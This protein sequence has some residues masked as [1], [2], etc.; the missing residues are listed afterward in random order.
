[1][2]NKA[3]LED[4]N[5]DLE[6]PSY[7]QDVQ[8]TFQRS[9]SDQIERVHSGP[10]ARI[11]ERDTEAYTDGRTTTHNFSYN[12]IEAP[13]LVPSTSIQLDDN[14]QRIQ[15]RGRS[16]AEEWATPIPVQGTPIPVQ[17]TPIPVQGEAIRH[18][19]K[20]SK[21]EI[22]TSP[23]CG[24]NSYENPLQKNSK[25]EIGTS[26]ACGSNSCENPLQVFGRDVFIKSNHHPCHDSAATCG[27]SIDSFQSLPEIT[28]NKKI[29]TRPRVKRSMSD[30][31]CSISSKFNDGGINAKAF[32]IRRNVNL[33]SC[34][35]GDLFEYRRWAR[36][37]TVV[38]QVLAFVNSKSGGQ[39]IEAIV[40]ELNKL[41]VAICDLADDL[42]PK[43]SLQKVKM[44]KNKNS[45]RFVVLGGDGTVTWLLHELERAHVHGSVAVIPLGTGNDLGRSL[46]WGAQLENI[47]DL[48]Q[49]LQWI[50]AATEVYLDIWRITVTTEVPLP[51]DHKFY[52]PGSHPRPQRKQNTFM[53][54]FQNYFSVGLDAR[55]CYDVEESRSHRT[56]FGTW[57]FRQGLGKLC[58]F[59]HI[60]KQCL[61]GIIFS[62]IITPDV[63]LEPPVNLSEHYIHSCLRK[64]RCRTLLVT[65]INSYGAGQKVYYGSQD[66]SDGCVEILAARNFMHGLAVM[67]QC[68][69]LHYVDSLPEV[70]FRF[71]EPT[72][73]QIDGEPWYMPVPCKVKIEHHTRAILLRAPKECPHWNPRQNIEFWANSVINPGEEG[74]YENLMHASAKTT[75]TGSDS[76]Q[77]F[78][79]GPSLQDDAW[80]PDY[81]SPFLISSTSSPSPNPEGM[82]G[83]PRYG[84][85]GVHTEGE[86]LN[87]SML[88]SS[89]V[90]G[91]KSP[92]GYAHRMHKSIA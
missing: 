5:K 10:L 25:I 68:S 81:T 64:G 90:A 44:R 71:K 2:N 36:T 15:E 88:D 47:S 39:V 70:T 51:P 43:L 40:A 19:E 35:I 38:Q 75:K 80:E 56:G 76:N 1:M 34:L 32:E 67:G 28:R 62:R 54:H 72:Y 11:T 31:Y 82:L 48:A 14:V 12:D 20:N 87:E 63:E 18:S 26:P 6:A 74:P 66:P 58:Y 21:I 57:I 83:H 49:Y 61:F 45:N 29:I 86:R 85:L 37:N 42:E 55:I 53:G 30:T 41:E 89:I 13:R 50:A 59:W 24:S 46:G 27:E 22:G 91:E 92:Y 8:Y 60:L 16:T 77:T 79:R 65:N 73:M 9:L 52:S 7:D 78:M 69:A 23:A 3:L 4:E 17:G 84:T 33:D